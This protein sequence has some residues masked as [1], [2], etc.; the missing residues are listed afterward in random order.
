V[1]KSRIHPSIH[2]LVVKSKTHPS[3]HYLCTVRV[4]FINP[5]IGF[6]SCAP[7]GHMCTLYL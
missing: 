7:A 3:I 1:I 4:Q 2:I 6:L 5:E